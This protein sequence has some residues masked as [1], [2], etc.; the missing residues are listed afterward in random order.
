MFSILG[1]GNRPGI[2]TMIVG[3]AL[4]LTGIGYAFYVKPILLKYK[5]AQLAA[6]A[7]AN[8]KPA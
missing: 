1:V 5:K 8:R 4:M 7:A 3:A 2:W 6:W